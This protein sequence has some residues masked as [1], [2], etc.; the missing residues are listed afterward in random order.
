MILQP[1]PLFGIVIL[2]RQDQ[3]RRHAVHAHARRQRTRQRAQMR[4]ACFD[5]V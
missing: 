1:A 2:R 4:S 5:S 3:A